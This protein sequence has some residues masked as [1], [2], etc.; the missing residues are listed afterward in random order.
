M[1]EEKIVESGTL[2][3]VPFKFDK[4]EHKISLIDELNKLKEGR[5]ALFSSIHYPNFLEYHLARRGKKKTEGSV[6]GKPSPHKPLESKEPEDIKDAYLNFY[7]IE[8]ESPENLDLN[9]IMTSNEELIYFKIRTIDLVINNSKRNNKILIGYWIIT[10]EWQQTDHNILLKLLSDTVFFRFHNFQDDKNNKKK[11]VLGRTNESIYLIDYIKQMA[12]QFNFDSFNYYQEK[13]TVVHL[14]NSNGLDDNEEQRR[15]T[16]NMQAYKLLRIP[17]IKWDESRLKKSLSEDSN[18][19][20]L[21]TLVGS[22]KMMVLDEGAIIIEYIYTLNEIKNKYAPAFL[23]A[24]NQREIIHFLILEIAK[25]SFSDKKNEQEIKDF[26]ELKWLLNQTKHDQLFHTISKNSEINMFFQELQDRFMIDQG[27][28]DIQESIEGMNEWMN[29]IQRKN[30]EQSQNN[31]NNIL[32][33][34][35]ILSV[36]SAFNDGYDLFDIK[37]QLNPNYVWVCLLIIIGFLFY[38]RFKPNSK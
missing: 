2:L 9:Y 5:T 26:E 34:I 25:E 8:V 11:I 23:L 14:I 6:G 18:T 33:A 38:T 17:P 37:G 15:I 35:T 31:L 30:Q 22:S 19:S 27:V 13:F 16:V 1:S 24:L 32:I 21:N 36:F 3:Y 10:I 29:E 7:N 28:K 12:P 20:K 4:L